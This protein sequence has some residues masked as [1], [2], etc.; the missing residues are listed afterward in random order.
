MTSTRSPFRAVGGTGRSGDAGPARERSEG[1]TGVP[2]LLLPVALALLGGLAVPH[3]ARAQEVRF[4]AQ[5]RPRYEYRDPS[6]DGGEAFVSMRV[7]AG[8]TALLEEDVRLFVQVQ[9]V[10][11]WGEE[12]STLGDFRADNFDLHQGYA[13]VGGAEG[14][15]FR[16]RAGRQEAVL[17]GERLVGAVGWTQQGRSF[18]GVR[19]TARAGWGAVDVLGFKT[20]EDLATDSPA[21][22][23]FLGAYAVLDGPRGSAVD[24]YALYSREGGEPGTDEGTL[25]ARWAGSSGVWRWR[26]EASYQFGERGGVDVSAYMLGVRAGASRA[27]GRGRLT[28]WYDLLS[29]DED[30]TDDE[31]G[32]FNTLFATNHK[33]YGFADLFL[34][35]P[36]HTAGRGL[37]DTAVKA[38]LDPRDDLH[39]GLD[40]HAFFLAE[41]AG[42]SSGHL[43][44]EIDLTVRYRYTPQLGV[45][46]GL[47]QVFADD[48][49]GEIG[50][51]AE[52]M[53]WVYLMLDVAF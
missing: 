24:L 26:A 45:T 30:P 5:V 1:G 28:L 38:A 11:L 44:E 23:G 40:L 3:P 4:G 36:V 7:R 12:T 10:R 42:L 22:A 9:D 19:V 6:A 50:R 43:G 33:F 51:L 32:V 34:N 29:G 25:G 15:G 27:D 53:T 8:F 37:H 13:E 47:S 49:L 48:A 2:G 46:A 35:I 39:V 21:D 41:D 52:D 16:L 20:G 17:G 18:D 31:V 14:P